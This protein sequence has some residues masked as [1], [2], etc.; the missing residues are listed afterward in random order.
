MRKIINKDVRLMRLMAAFIEWASP[1]GR[2]LR[3]KEVVDEFDKYL[4][5][6]LDLIR[7][8]SNCSQL[9]RNFSQDAKRANLLMVPE[10]FWDYCATDVFT[11][12]RMHGIQ[13]SRIKALVAAGVDL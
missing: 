10:V 8:A 2:R 5:D 3:P 4:N 11:M 7:E 1:D 13:V 6:E 12:E 9:R